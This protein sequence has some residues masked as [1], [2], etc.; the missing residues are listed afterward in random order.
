MLS[1]KKNKI[2]L[3]IPNSK[4]HGAQ[5]FFFRLNSVLETDGI[6]SEL[7]IEENL[8][9]IQTILYLLRQSH[10]HNLSI[11]STVNSNVTALLI[12]FINPN[13]RVF[14]RLGNTISMEIKKNTLKFFIHKYFYK[15]LITVSTKFIFQC[16]YMKDDFSSF[17]NIYSDKYC[18]INNGSFFCTQQ[19]KK[20]DNKPLRCLLVGTFKEQK[21][22]D[23]FFES[24]SHIFN[25]S[26][27]EIN[28]C[29]D[30]PLLEYFK[31]L[32]VRR[33][34]SYNIQFHNFVD[35]RSLYEE[36]DFYVLPSRFE[37]FSNSLIEALSYGLP[38]IASNGP[39]ANKEVI[40]DNINGLIFQNEDPI[41][42]ATKINVMRRNLKD[43]SPKKISQVANAKFNINIIAS[44][45]IDMINYVRN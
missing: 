34:D 39:G 36:S 22:Y 21:G 23:I 11:I 44:E 20:K 8:S 29:G 3:I 30:G 31:Y 9:K 19:I 12:K 7:L 18:V 13:I 4:K 10:K 32:K 43:F 14:P 33:Y 38:C 16:V 27:L 41:D 45:Y 25:P 24:L 40:D 37:G 26:D 15:L 5:N 28:I 2:I 35:P 17:F 42:L 1:S 6:N